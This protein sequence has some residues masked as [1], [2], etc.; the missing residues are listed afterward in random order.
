MTRHQIKIRR[1]HVTSGR[2]R[3]H[4]NFGALQR[5]HAR[6]AQRRRLTQLFAGLLLAVSLLLGLYL[7]NR[8]ARPDARAP[9]PELQPLVTDTV[10]QPLLPAGGSTPL[11]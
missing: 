6:A 3:N 2:I 7:L 4:R 8:P 1:E 10:M 5:E 11:R 9:H